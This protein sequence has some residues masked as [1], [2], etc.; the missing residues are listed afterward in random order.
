MT[1]A[2]LV[3]TPLLSVAQAFDRQ[4]ADTFFCGGGA[5]VKYRGWECGVP[6]E[7]G[8]EVLDGH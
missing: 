3:L 7:L 8:H 1:I 2:T 4:F 5:E 6:D